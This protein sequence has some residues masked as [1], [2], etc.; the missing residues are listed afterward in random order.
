[1]RPQPPQP[2]RSIAAPGRLD[3]D[4]SDQRAGKHRPAISDRGR[5]S[6]PRE[7]RNAAARRRGNNQLLDRLPMGG[8]KLPLIY[9]GAILAGL[10]CRYILRW[11]FHLSHIQ[12][13]KICLQFLPLFIQ[14]LRQAID[15]SLQ[16][17]QLALLVVQLLKQTVVVLV[18]WLTVFMFS[19]MRCCSAVICW[20]AVVCRRSAAGW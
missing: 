20:T 10:L 5:C 7:D 2:C 16:L 4:R 19:R 9:R 14:R 3:R 12:S 17:F 1:M 18:C 8:V 11:R 6:C 13:L 15:L